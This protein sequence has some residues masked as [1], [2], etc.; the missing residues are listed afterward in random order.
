M[1]SG[2]PEYMAAVREEIR[3]GADFIKIMG[4]GGV[5]SPTDKLEQLQFTSAEIQAMVECANNAGALV[6]A[7][8]HTVKAV[9]HCIEHGVKGIEY[10]NFVDAPTAK[11]MAHKGIYLT[12]TL[13]AYAQILSEQWKG[14]LPPESQAK[15][16]QMLKSGLE[17]LRIASDADVTM[18]YGSDVLGPLGSA[19]THE[20]AL[21]S[22]VPKDLLKLL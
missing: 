2:V 17:A 6:A 11:M 5:A 12:P 10:G 8:A 15:N 13:I 21:Q 22:R 20:F 14:Y 3:C 1:C 16:S 18:C 7:H 9:R 19:Q 4:S